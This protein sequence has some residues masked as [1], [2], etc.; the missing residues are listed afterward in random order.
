M[1]GFKYHIAGAVLSLY[2]S[3]PVWALTIADVPLF[4]STTVSPNVMLLIDNSGSMDHITWHS[5]Y[6]DSV[7][8]AAAERCIGTN[9][10]GQCND[11]SVLS[12]GSTYYPGSVLQA[13]CASGERLFRYGLNTRCLVMPDPVG[14]GNTRFKGN[15]LSYLVGQ[16]VANASIPNQ[17]RMMVAR[18]VSKS[19]VTNNPGMRF[20][21]MSFDEN[22]DD[23]GGKLKAAAGTSASTINSRIDNLYSATWTP[24][25]EA[26]YEMTRYY[27]GMS[28]NYTSDDF[29]SP[30]Q[31]R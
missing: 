23:D 28:A 27:R 25:A 18:N 21:F 14:N 3:S 24:L 15:Y 2:A 8:Y 9:W 20:G 5:G 26:Y 30:I 7:T 29:T 16:G 1:K 4:Q 10:K 19:I 13:G 6:Q 22:D 17:H 31:Y 12:A 11:W